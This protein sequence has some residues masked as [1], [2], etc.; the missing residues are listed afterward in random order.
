[1]NAIQRYNDDGGAQQMMQAAPMG[2]MLPMGGGM[3]APGGALASIASNAEVMGELAS[4]Y[5]AKSFPVTPAGTGLP[6][7]PSKRRLAL[8]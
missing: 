2:G 3:A 5:I 4:I 8:P 6:V 1:M 7:A